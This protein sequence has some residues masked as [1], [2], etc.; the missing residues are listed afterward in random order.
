MKSDIKSSAAIEFS[1]SIPIHYE[2]FLGPM[3]FEPYAIE[4]SKRIDPSSVQ[5]ALELA[6]G[7]GRVTRH[8]RNAISSDARLIASDISLDMLAVAKEK[9]QSANID[10]QII[11]AQDLPYDDNSIDVVVCCFGYMLVPDRLKAYKEAY[12]VLKKGGMLLIATWDKLEHNAASYVYR[13]VAKKYLEEPLPAAWNLP[14]SMNDDQE[15]KKDLQLA[16]FSEI[17]IEKVEKIAVSPTA[18]DA[19]NGLA[20]GGLIYNEIMKRNPAWADEIEETVEIELAE[21]F[22]KAPVNAPMS[23]LIT[24]AFK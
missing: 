15:I 9:L 14:F 13:T 18:K 19:A 23:A 8:L 11:D 3:F 1:G 12:R 5:I 17:V 21:K 4:V 20:R 10:W 2:A 16:G 22:G 7:T 6:C 24:Q